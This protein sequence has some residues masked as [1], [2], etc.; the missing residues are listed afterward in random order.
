MIKM[1]Q[2]VTIDIKFEGQDQ[3]QQDILV[4]KLPTHTSWQD[5]QAMLKAQFDCDAISVFYI[6]TEGDFISVSS[7][8]ELKMAFQMAT[9]CR[10]TLVLKVKDTSP[11]TAVWTIDDA[12]LKK[13]EPDNLPDIQPTDKRNENYL[14]NMMDD[15]L[16]QPELFHQPDILKTSEHVLFPPDDIPDDSAL[17]SGGGMAEEKVVMDTKIDNATGETISHSDMKLE[18]SESTK[19]GNPEVQ[20]I[21]IKRDEETGTAH[22][23]VSVVV[24][25][26]IKRKDKRSAEKQDSRRFTQ[27]ADRSSRSIR[28]MCDS[29]SGEASYDEDPMPYS[30]FVKFMQQLKTDLRQEI[31]KDVTRKT[32]K[33]VLKGLDGAVIHSL[34]GT[35]IIPP[36]LDDSTADSKDPTSSHPIYYHEGIVC[37]FCER[38]IVGVRY[39][40]C[41][42]A[43]YDLCEECEAIHGVHDSDHV[44][45]KLRKPARLGKRTVI[46][47][48]TLY[49]VKQGTTTDPNKKDDL[50]CPSDMPGPLEDFIKTKMERLQE[51]TARK[52]EKLRKREEKIV[53]KQRKKEEKLKRRLECHRDH[54][55]KREKLDLPPPCKIGNKE[56]DASFVCDVNV[57]DGT[58][59]QP[60]TKL[61]KTWKLKNTGSK[62]WTANTKLRLVYGSIPTPS[63][64]IGV[65][66]VEP[67]QEC[68]VTVELQAPELPGRYQSHWKMYNDG[69][70]FG[71]RVWCEIQVE[72]KEVLEAI[73]EDS[74]KFVKTEETQLIKEEKTIDSEEKTVMENVPILLPEPVKVELPDQSAE[75]IERSTSVIE[76]KPQEASPPLEEAIKQD[77][78]EK[79]LSSAVA[80]LKLDS[81][82]EER[83]QD[84]MSFEMVDYTQ[85]MTPKISQTATPTNTPLDISP[86]KSP[87]PELDNK[88]LS[89]SSSVELV[90][91]EHEEEEQHQ[92]N[93]LFVKEFMNKFQVPTPVDDDIESISTISDDDSSLSED[94]DFLIVPLPACFDFSKPM[95]RSAIVNDNLSDDNDVDDNHNNIPS[96]YSE[97]QEEGQSVDEI[98]TTS[99]TLATPPLNPAQNADFQQEN[100]NEAADKG[101]ASSIDAVAAELG[102]TLLQEV[103]ATATASE[104]PVTTT[105]NVEVP[106]TPAV[107][108]AG[109]VDNYDQNVSSNDTAEMTETKEP[110]DY[111]DYSEQ[112]AGY[113]GGLLDNVVIEKSDAK[114]ATGHD[115][116][117][118]EQSPGEF[119]NQIMSTAVNAANKAAANAYT[120]CKEVFYTWQART[121]Q[122]GSGKFTSTQSTW[123]PKEEKWTP[124]ENTF[125]PPKSDWTPPKDTWKPPSQGISNLSSTSS[126]KSPMGKLVEMGFCNRDLNQELLKKHN[127]DVEAVVQDLLS[128]TD[129]DWWNRRH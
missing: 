98:L 3:N 81:A 66:E 77:E 25:Q 18:E 23:K 69:V 59:V 78:I 110:L 27:S 58:C 88:V 85:R 104:V 15:S 54:P 72:P 30:V 73:K 119:V 9:K 13:P 40:C 129:N 120:T 108:A 84:L 38:S 127:D 106:P 125:V 10:N 101:E 44:F 71:H 102:E 115:Q 31:V 20:K 26:K 34:Q 45:L 12:V 33:Q 36:V 76:E 93:P 1:A 116:R 50:N 100:I 17:F 57:P 51:R 28:N 128:T 113:T 111:D 75:L 90:N 32:V 74:L 109:E 122:N 16:P 55:T 114:G 19:T 21:E 95:T 112:A 118:G 8:E 107:G 43:N 63:N 24:K 4:F 86:P 70:Q 52:Q 121:Y 14:E 67:D 6:D 56:F 2:E 91:A 60:G 96:A 124:K 47:K 68:D 87:A 103:H 80:Q 48:N 65:P 37:D 49:K 92:I 126:S 105:I 123:K 41:N 99:G 62:S 61:Q 42:C 46:L 89:S 83:G 97:R 35:P 39:K 5:L 64:D 94:D 22:P 53:E 79:D 82:S 29:E 11:E 117:N 7:N